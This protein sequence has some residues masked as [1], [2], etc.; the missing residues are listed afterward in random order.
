LRYVFESDT[1]VTFYFDSNAKIYDSVSS[2]TITDELKVL[3][4]NTQPGTVTPFTKDLSWRIVSEYI[5]QDGYVDPKK[6]IVSFADSDNNG[7]V[8]NPS[9]FTDIVT[10]PNVAD[11]TYVV[12]QRYII[13]DGQEDYKYIENDP[14]V[15]PVIIRD[16]E[17]FVDRS[18]YAGKYF[19]FTNSKVVKLMDST[20]SLAPSLDYKVYLGD[21]FNNDF[22][23]SARFAGQLAT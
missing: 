13:S 2:S 18:V 20:G 11:Q 12:Q 17:D 3:S 5:G 6:I 23:C 4:I 9:L 19:Y 22:Q 1:D 8:D 10:T 14:D 21:A 15:G 7:V 16:T